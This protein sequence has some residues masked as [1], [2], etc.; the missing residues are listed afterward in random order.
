M[1][2]PVEEE[3][4]EEVI[5]AKAAIFSLSG[6]G[7][8]GAATSVRTQRMLRNLLKTRREAT[9]VATRAELASRDCKSTFSNGGTGGRA[10]KSWF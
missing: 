7:F 3:V 8:S 10:R 2:K 1:K 9:A 6:G 5:D 4:E